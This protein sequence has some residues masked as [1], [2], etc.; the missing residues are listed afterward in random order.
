[1][2]SFTSRIG[3]VLNGVPGKDLK[4]MADEFKKLGW[5]VVSGSSD[6]HLFSLNVMSFGVTGK[7]AA[8]VTKLIHPSTLKSVYAH[9]LQ[10]EFALIAQHRT[11][12]RNDSFRLFFF[13]RISIPA[14]LKIDAIDI[15]SFTVE[16]H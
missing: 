2:A 9:P 5:S 6:N 1:M 4:G 7:Q 8:T 16:Q 10:R 3:R 15:I 13:F 12:T 14:Q 11:D